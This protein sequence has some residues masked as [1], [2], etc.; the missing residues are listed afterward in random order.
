L[1]DLIEKLFV[2]HLERKDLA[3]KA[4]SGSAVGLDDAR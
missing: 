4:S 2:A 3:S 1:A